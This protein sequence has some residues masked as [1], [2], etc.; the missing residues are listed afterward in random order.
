M[1]VFDI[2]PS[3]TEERF[4]ELNGLVGLSNAFA[5]ETFHR[6]KD[7]SLF[8]VEISANNVEFDGVLTGFTF[9]KDITER[10]Q[11]EE[12]LQRQRQLLEE[13]NST[14]EQRVREEVAK[15]REKDVMLIQQN[16]QASLGEILDHI[17]HQWKQPLATIS[18]LAYLLKTNQAPSLQ[19]VHE[20][21]DNI[22]EQ[23]THLTQLLN[24]FRDFYRPDKE[25]T[26]FLVKESIDR[27][28][29][30]VMPALRFEAIALDVDVDPGLYAL[31]YPNEFCQVI[32]NLVSNSRDAF[33]EKA[34]EKRKLSIRSFAEDSMAVVTISDTA[35]GISESAMPEIFQ[36]NFTTKEKSGGTGVGL[37]MARTIIER[38]MDG[39]L[40]ATNLTDGAQF[41]IRLATAA[42]PL[43]QEPTIAPAKTG[44]ALQRNLG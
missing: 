38:D 13:L 40:T 12:Q 26:V 25:K 5:L 33:K 44:G 15:N 39:T 43:P 20:T 31:G 27:A 19:S 32:L 42:V 10:R 29:A 23:T 36:M 9:V 16:R 6:R 14:L 18:L 35:G 1:T 30:F 2:N 21:A 7:G 28:L 17:A 41:C 4:S 11:A 8:P 34:V 22:T 24:D 3:L 37:Y